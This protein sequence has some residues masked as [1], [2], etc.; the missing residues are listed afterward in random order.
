MTITVIAKS[1][2][3]NIDD[4]DIVAKTDVENIYVSDQKSKDPNLNVDQVPEIVLGYRNI[5]T[6][7]PAIGRLTNLK[8]LFLQYNSICELPKEIGDLRHLRFFDLEGNLLKRLPQSFKN[9][10]QLEWVKLQRNRLIKLPGP[11]ILKS[12]EKHELD[13][14]PIQRTIKRIRQKIWNFINKNHP[15]APRE[16]QEAIFQARFFASKDIFDEPSG[17]LLV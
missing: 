9:L 14:N 12:L 1:K 8:S 7:G 13:K 17:V 10:T 16:I 15:N 2:D 5:E 11:F 4:N 6:L 3:I